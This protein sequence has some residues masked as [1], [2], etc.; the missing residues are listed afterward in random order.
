MTDK[1]I[2][3]DFDGVLNFFNLDVFTPWSSDKDCLSKDLIQKIN[4]IISVTNAKVI[5]SSDWRHTRSVEELQNLL[6]SL[7]FIGTIIDKTISDS[8]VNLSKKE[9]NILNSCRSDQIL[10]SID[11]HK[12]NNFVII[13][14]NHPGGLDSNL[15]L[16]DCNTGINDQDVLKC[17]KILNL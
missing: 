3:L 7:G 6:D 14:D 11:R 12:I 9:K 8:D 13:D 2:F 15:V 4:N 16:T 1:I 5:V 10:H 17:I